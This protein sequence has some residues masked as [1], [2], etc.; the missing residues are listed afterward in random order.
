MNDDSPGTLRFLPVGLDVRGRDCVVVGGGSVGTRKADTLA[1]AGADVTVV[2]PAVT[3]E[4][5]ARIEAGRICWVS[6]CFREEHLSGAFLVVAA[7]DDEALNATVARLAGRRGALVCDASSADRSA[8]I[9]GALLQRDEVTI[10]VFTGGRDPAQAR[11]TRD[12][13]GK[14][15][16]DGRNS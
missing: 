12:K 11:S 4:L 15:L 6:D 8:V 3:E 10:A 7:T 1:R 2:S 9:F 13:I 14:L 5:A 16:A